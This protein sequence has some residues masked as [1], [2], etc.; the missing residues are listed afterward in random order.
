MVEKEYAPGFSVVLPN[1]NGQGLLEKN[2][3]PL[4]AAL[5]E[6]KLPFEIIVADDCSTDHSVD[7]LQRSYPEIKLVSTKINSG[8]ATA[9]NTG[10]AEARFEYTCI[11]N[12]DVTFD[13]NYFKNSIEYFENPNLFAIKGDIINY[14]DRP[15]D[16]LDIQKDVAVYLKRG[17]FKFMPAAD[18]ETVNYDHILV[19]LGCCFVCRTGLIKKIGAYDELFSPYYWEDL[20]LALTVIKKGYDLDYAPNCVVY[21]QQSSTIKKTQSAIKIRLISTR[22]KFFLAWKHLDSPARWSSHIFFVLGSLCL[23]WLVLDWKYYVALAYALARYMRKK[24]KTNSLLN[25]E[26]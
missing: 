21:H 18:K 25:T 11:V 8:F 5:T 1:Y 15:D 13:L 24:K 23:R 4:Y 19:L 12:T 2:L 14:Q 3:P 9:C 20:D 16:I 7:Y 26:G 22:N 6:A 10:I 17:F